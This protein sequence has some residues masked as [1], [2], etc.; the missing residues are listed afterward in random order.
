M[1]YEDLNLVAISRFCHNENILRSLLDGRNAPKRRSTGNTGKSEPL[2]Q[3][4]QTV[5]SPLI[6]SNVGED[7]YSFPTSQQAAYSPA[8]KQAIF[9]GCYGTTV[10][11]DWVLHQ[12]NFWK[13][14]FTREAESSL[15]T[16]LFGIDPADLPQL[17]NSK[18]SQAETPSIGKKWKGI[19]AFLDPKF[20][21]LVRKEDGRDDIED[22]FS[23]ADNG[24]VFQDMKIKTC[25]HDSPANATAMFQDALNFHMPAKRAKTRS[26]EKD[27]TPL[28]EPRTFLMENLGGGGTEG[29]FRSDGWLSQLPSQNGIPG[30]QRLTMMKYWMDEDNNIDFMTLWAY[31]GV[32]LPGG[33]VIV[34]RWWSPDEVANTDEQYSGPCLM[35]NTN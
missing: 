25:I 34:G 20:L 28:T 5:L 16:E 27:D 1:I 26:G 33:R 17:W 8:T 15:Y 2:L 32:M 11:M 35:W 19:S 4:L 14:H 13:Y 3:T 7:L 31:E 24:G 18:L 30:W 9:Q 12:I 22:E 21:D 29:S 10:N 23:G 6:L